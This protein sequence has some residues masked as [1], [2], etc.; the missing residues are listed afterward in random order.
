MFS[1]NQYKIFKQLKLTKDD[2]VNITNLIKNSTEDELVCYTSSNQLFY[3]DLY[4]CEESIMNEMDENNDSDDNHY[5][6]SQLTQSYH[7]GGISAMD[8]CARKSL[9]ATCSKDH[10]LRIWNYIDHNVELIKYF[11]EEAYCLSI[12]PS[13]LYIIVGFNDKLRFMNILVDD[14]RTFK[15][16]NIRNCRECQFSNGGQYFAAVCGND[17]HIY[18]TWTF[19]L[20]NVMTGHNG[21]INSVKWSKDDTKM[22]SCGKDGAVYL[23]S[24]IDYAVKRREGEHVLK[25]CDYTCAV[26]A[27]NNSSIYVVGSD[28]TLKE[29][30]DSQVTREMYTKEVYTQL[31]L[32]NSG[33]ML[34]AGTNKGTIR[35]LRYPFNSTDVVEY[36]E[37]KAHS[38]AVTSLQISCDDKYLFSAGEDGNIFIFQINEKDDKHR[39]SVSYG[40]EMLITKTELEEKISKIIELKTRLEELKLEKDYQLRNN[41]VDFNKEK[42]T[43]IKEHRGKLEYLNNENKNLKNL[44]EYEREKHEEKFNKEIDNYEK[45]IQELESLNNYKLMSKYRKYEQ[46]EVQLARIQNKW[47]REVKE[48]N[49][50]NYAELEKLS[51]YNDKILNEKEDDINNLKDKLYKQNKENEEIIRQTK[52]D[53]EIEIENLKSKYDDIIKGQKETAAYMKG[54]NGIMKKKFT[55]FY[56]EIETHKVEL[57]RIQAECRRL[58]DIISKME[59]NIASVN[60]E[61]LVREEMVHDK[62]KNIFDLKKE[63]QELEK[64]KYVL[65][66]K[67]KE[68]K[69]QIEPREHEIDEIS[70]KIIVLDEDLQVFK[71]KNQNFEHSIED[72][73]EKISNL[74]QMIEKEKVTIRKYLSI[75]TKFRVSLNDLVDVILEP[76]LLKKTFER[77]CKQFLEYVKD[78]EEEDKMDEDTHNEI[79]RQQNTMIHQIKRYKNQIIEEEK[80]TNS[81]LASMLNNNIELISELSSLLC[82]VKIERSRFTNTQRTLKRIILI[83]QQAEKRENSSQKYI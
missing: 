51:L 54:E 81:E 3:I 63:N 34:F 66:Y 45:T 40:N 39:V 56:A 11:Q 48:I 16:F 70:E 14:I 65:D 32:S 57:E 7:T 20:L 41:D 71:K 21:K 31:I 79:L 67:I 68:L 74:I 61:I 52:E 43:L 64:Y 37:H 24:V 33:K 38:K 15:E 46:L 2:T 82:Q 18:S 77:V 59:K 72:V 17:I 36:R 35:A 73:K 58:K 62:E 26:L 50:K 76:K 80:Q 47:E 8:V 42:N 28:K 12:H 78:I 10:T 69:T 4:K 19:E 25:N 6:Y 5:L 23:W 29:I 53:S 55:S 44:I 27:H 49:S 83:A 60:R 9:I 30:E 1:S 75:V 22:V 13:G